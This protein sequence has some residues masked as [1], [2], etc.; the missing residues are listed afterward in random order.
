MPGGHYLWFVK[1]NQPTLL[2]D[3]QTAFTA[4]VEADF[5]P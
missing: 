4:S 1:E 3:I 2:H 5:S